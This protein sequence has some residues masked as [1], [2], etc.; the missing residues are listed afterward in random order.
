MNA[1][2]YHLTGTPTGRF[3]T[4]AS[5]EKITAKRITIAGMGTFDRVTGKPT[6][7][8]GDNGKLLGWETDGVKYAT[9]AGDVYNEQA[10]DDAAFGAWVQKQWSSAQEG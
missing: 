5:V 7:F 3:V 4:V 10:Q 2:I 6:A 9:I 8:R 1:Y